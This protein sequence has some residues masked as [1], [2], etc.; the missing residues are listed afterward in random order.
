MVQSGTSSSALVKFS[1]SPQRRIHSGAASKF[2]VIADPS[3]IAKVELN[4]CPWFKQ[5]LKHA[6]NFGLGIVP[7]QDPQ[8]ISGLEGII[9]GR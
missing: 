7:F 4:E 3:A 9:R 2:A 1:G 5:L 6:G 8:I